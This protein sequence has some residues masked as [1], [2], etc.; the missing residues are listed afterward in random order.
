M[1]FSKKV[2][3]LKTSNDFCWKSLRKSGMDKTCRPFKCLTFKLKIESFDFYIQL[4][5]TLFKRVDGSTGNE[6]QKK[7]KKFNA[8]LTGRIFHEEF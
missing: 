2:V 8:V 7:E 4:L 5:L 6:K 3:F 1:V